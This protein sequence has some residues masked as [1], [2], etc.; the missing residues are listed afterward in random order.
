MIA[1][2]REALERNRTGTVLLL[3]ALCFVLLGSALS[4]CSLEDLVRVRVPEDVAEAI[5]SPTSIPVS[6]SGDAWDD[7]QAWVERE[8]ERFAREID[9]GQEIAGVIRSLTE[10]GLRLGQDAASTLPGGAIISAGLAGLGGL[11]LRR[12]GDAKRERLEKEASYNAGLEK[13][14]EIAAGLE[15]IHD[16]I[17]AEDEPPAV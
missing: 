5:D 6:Q 13:G 9:R 10:T 3:G 15:A 2:L 8:S 12:P 11:F 7:W 1:T 14:R 17:H 4:A 16:A